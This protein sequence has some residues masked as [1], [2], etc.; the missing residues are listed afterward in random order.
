MQ[1]ALRLIRSLT[2]LVT[3]T[4]VVQL[5]LQQVVPI[6]PQVLLEP[7]QQLALLLQPQPMLV[8][9]LLK[10]PR[11]LLVLLLLSSLPLV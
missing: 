9:E 4:P 1:L 8:Q 7:L 11:L 10:Q 2:L 5:V 6:Q 3:L